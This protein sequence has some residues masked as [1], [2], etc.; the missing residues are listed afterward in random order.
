[1]PAP[2]E[3]ES[4]RY[5][6]RITAVKDGVATVAY[7]H[8]FELEIGFSATFGAKVGAKVENRGSEPF[9]GMAV[10]AVYTRTGRLA[11]T[12]QIM[13]ELAA[14]DAAQVEF[15]LDAALYPAGDYTYAVYCWDS[16]FAPVA[17]AARG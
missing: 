16:G 14:G 7:A 2:S 17:P 4:G 1:V 8:A 9:S 10:L 13:V 6:L 12:E 15:A 3:S 11:R 5:E